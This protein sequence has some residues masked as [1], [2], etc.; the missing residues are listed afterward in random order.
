MSALNIELFLLI[1]AAPS[2]P[3]TIIS[4]A[5]FCAKYL[6]LLP[7]VFMLWAWLRQPLSREALIKM[8]FSIMLALIMVSIIRLMIESPRPFTLNLGTNFLTH[9][10]TPS[11]PSRHTVFIATT[12]LSAWLNYRALPAAKKFIISSLIFTLFVGWSRIYLGVHWPFDII[13]A[14]L[15]SLIASLI[16]QYV[17]R[18]IKVPVMSLTLKVHRSIFKALIKE[19]LIKE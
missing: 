11:F 12:A 10:P 15:V 2:A 14:L 6:P 4:F 16:I 18:Y 1:N 17:W 19:G 5:L 3:D 8:G 9:A 7:P 13:G